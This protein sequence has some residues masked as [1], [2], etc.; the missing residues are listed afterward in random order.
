MAAATITTV[1]TSVFG[2]K[3]I[4]IAKV[5]AADTNTWDTGLSLVDFFCAVSTTN[6]AVGGT[7]SGGT[8]TFQT[9]GTETDMMVFVVG[10]G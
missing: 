9:G 4:L 5:T 1:Q 7:F 6:N 2:D 3:R 8:I 10:E